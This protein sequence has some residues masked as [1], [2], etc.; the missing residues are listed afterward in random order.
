MLTYLCLSKNRQNRLHQFGSVTN[1]LR[2]GLMTQCETFGQRGVDVFFLVDGQKGKES[3]RQRKRVTSVDVIY[4]VMS[5]LKFC[6]K[7]LFQNKEMK[8]DSFDIFQ[9][10]YIVLL[11]FG[12]CY[13]QMRFK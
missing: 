2:G 6:S 13:K 1:I 11:L 5:F 12:I 7:T 10:L 8:G 9:K 4:G 3:D